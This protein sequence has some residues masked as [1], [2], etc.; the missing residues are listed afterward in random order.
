MYLT[1]YTSSDTTFQCQTLCVN[2]A[3]ITYQDYAS[4][5]CNSPAFRACLVA[6]IKWHK[7]SKAHFTIEQTSFSLKEL[8]FIPVEVMCVNL[9]EVCSNC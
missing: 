8:A 9:A 2:V 7:K 5:Y 1:L 4:G 3:G 6:Y